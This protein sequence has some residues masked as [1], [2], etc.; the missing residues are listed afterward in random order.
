MRD[1]SDMIN[2][3]EA[4]IILN[5]PDNVASPVGKIC[6]SASLSK[7]NQSSVEVG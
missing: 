3:K 2:N 7:T 4:V 5:F 1:H 6:A